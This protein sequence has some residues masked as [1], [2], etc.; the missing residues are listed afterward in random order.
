MKMS[1]VGREC[2]QRVL[3]REITGSNMLCNS[4][5]LDAALVQRVKRPKYVRNLNY[6]LLHSSEVFKFC[7]QCF[8][9]GRL[10]HDKACGLSE[11]C[12]DSVGWHRAA[13]SHQ[14][15]ARGIFTIAVFGAA[16]PTPL[17][18]TAPF[19]LK[20]PSSVFLAGLGYTVF[21]VPCFRSLNTTFH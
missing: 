20:P 3:R 19:I 11:W 8:A 9:D 2:L 17:L 4:H 7:Y 21:G 14:A 6:A 16:C 12:S 13:A 10:R 5:T 1:G 18:T 15:T